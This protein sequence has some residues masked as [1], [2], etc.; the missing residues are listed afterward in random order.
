M[1]QY[2]ICLS[3]P[4]IT[5]NENMSNDDEKIVGF[6]SLA[7][8][9]VRL[10]EHVEK[11]KI[12]KRKWFENNLEQTEIQRMLEKDNTERWVRIPASFF[13]HLLSNPDLNA[14]FICDRVIAHIESLGKKINFDN[15][16][17]EAQMWHKMSNCNIVRYKDG[18]EEVIHSEHGMGKNVS[19]FL[20]V[21]INNMIFKTDDYDLLSQVITTD[22]F[23]LKI[24][25]KC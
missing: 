23:T 16:Y 10:N 11:K 14:V 8:N 19:E 5:K 3:I 12:T 13:D 25:R 4:T 17:L 9:Q 7:S 18:D 2:Q 24:K 1:Y 20:A 22:N 21:L 15:L 6:R